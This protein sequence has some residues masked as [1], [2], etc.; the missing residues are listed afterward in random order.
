MTDDDRNRG[1]YR[2]FG[3]APIADDPPRSITARLW[4][5]LV[6]V[7]VLVAGGLIGLIAIDDDILDYADSA[8]EFFFWPGLLAFA[9]SFIGLS[10]GDRFSAL[11]RFALSI[12]AASLTV[13]LPLVVL[14]IVWA[15]TCASSSC[16]QS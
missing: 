11:G 14:V 9:L 13:V 5:P 10:L 16:V 2:P 4:W 6:L 3:G 1:Y 7:P 8:F 12:I 15:I